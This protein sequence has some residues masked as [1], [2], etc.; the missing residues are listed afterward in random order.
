[1]FL[2]YFYTLKEILKISLRYAEI[3]S[4][5]YLH[6][7]ITKST[8]NYMIILLWILQNL[9]IGEKNHMSYSFL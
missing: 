1:M 4:L 5:I 2:I 6:I 8:L 9:M 7:R 3:Y